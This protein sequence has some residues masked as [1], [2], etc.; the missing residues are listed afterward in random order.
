MDDVYRSPNAP[1]FI[2]HRHDQSVLT[3]LSILHS[4]D[5]LLAKDPS[6]FGMADQDPADLNLPPFLDHHRQRLPPIQHRVTVVTPT[7]G[8]PYLERCIASV[9]AQTLPGVEHLL[10]VDGQEHAEAVEAIV[11][12]FQFKNPIHVMVLP[13]NT[14]KDGWN[15]H[16]V[17][18][19]VPFLL[20]CAHVAYLDEDNTY[21]PDHLAGMQ[22]LLL[23][24]GLDWVFSLRKI[25]DK[26]GTVIAHDNCESLGSLCHTVLGWNDFLV[27]TSCYLFKTDVARAAAPHWMHRARAADGVEADRAVTK[28]LLTHPT[29]KGKGTGKHTLNYMVASNASMSVTGQ[30]FLDGNALFKYGFAARPTVY[31]FHFD[32]QRTAQ[33]LRCM[34]AADRS[35]AL[36]EWQMTLLAC[37]RGNTT[38]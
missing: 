26:D 31:V 32:P 25:V 30:F 24:E 21:D 18:A 11:A 5:V 2:D 10:V 3:N 13:F 37:S 12:A 33:F 16:H 29:F 28:F 15:G 9:Q 7:I 14:G 34:H 1:D 27:D 22:A 8:T 6:Q 23:R 19:S 36:D 35:Y 17:Y 4:P 38:S 20:D